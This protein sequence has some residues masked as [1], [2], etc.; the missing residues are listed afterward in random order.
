MN[1][2]LEQIVKRFQQRPAAWEIADKQQLN[3]IF[4]RIAA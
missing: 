2:R 4:Q 3:G 1:H